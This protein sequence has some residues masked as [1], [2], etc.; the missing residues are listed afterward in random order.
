MKLTLDRNTK[1]GTTEMLKLKIEDHRIKQ[2]MAKDAKKLSQ[3][4][5]MNSAVKTKKV[6]F[7]DSGK[8]VRRVLDTRFRDSGH[9]RNH[10]FNMCFNQMSKRTNHYL[11]QGAYN[12][13][14]RKIYSESL[15]KIPIKF[16]KQ[17]NEIAA[18]DLEKFEVCGRGRYNNKPRSSSQP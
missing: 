2:K 5:K 11:K 12:Q 14:K 10:N 9:Q 1:H 3:Y 6:N 15:G 17:E 13:E 16:G 8:K 7:Q 18:V 4:R